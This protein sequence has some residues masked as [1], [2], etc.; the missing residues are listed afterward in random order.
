MN[1]SL[2]PFNTFII[3]C[4][5]TLES[6]QSGK[7]TF[8]FPSSLIFP[9]LTSILS[10][11]FNSIIFMRSNQFNTFQRDPLIE[12]ITVIG[13]IPGKSSGS[14]HGVGLIDGSFDKGDF[15]RASRRRVHGG[16]KTINVSNNHEL[17]TLAPLGLSNLEPPFLATTKVPSIKHSD[18]SMSPRFSRSFASVSRI[19]RITPAL[20]Q[21]L[22]RRKQVAPEGN[23]S[24]KSI[25]AAPVRNTHITPFIT[26]RSLCS[27]GRPLPSARIGD[28]V[29]IGDIKDHCSSV[30][31]SRLVAIKQRSKYFTHTFY[32]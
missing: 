32:L 2:K 10:R 5:Y 12:R 4:Y 22:K 29:I 17:R 18:K 16:W 6:I 28:G 14:S 20:T 7:K 25:H 11:R 8:N 19:C 30:K 1:K 23:L 27:R 3:S 15:M 13:T 24:S 31:Y 9:K 26:S 21:T